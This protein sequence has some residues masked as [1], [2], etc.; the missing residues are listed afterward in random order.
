MECSRSNDPVFVLKN[1][2]VQ[3]FAV[4]IREGHYF[5]LAVLD[6]LAPSRGWFGFVEDEGLAGIGMIGIFGFFWSWLGRRG[7]GYG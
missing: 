6:D 5:F 3:D 1:E 2:F 4:F 7:A